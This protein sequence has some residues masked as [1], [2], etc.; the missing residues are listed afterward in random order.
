MQFSETFEWVNAFLQTIYPHTLHKDDTRPHFLL[1][2]LR[3]TKQSYMSTGLPSFPIMIKSHHDVLLPNDCL[4]YIFSMLSEDDLFRMRLVNRRW[5]RISLEDSIW[6]NLYA[7]RFC[8]GKK[9]ELQNIKFKS[10]DPE[11]KPADV[12]SWKQLYFESVSLYK[13]RNM[14]RARRL[15]REAVK[16]SLLYFTTDMFASLPFIITF[17]I[18][19]PLHKLRPRTV[20]FCFT[21][22]C[23]FCGLRVGAQV[24]R[25]RQRRDDDD[26]D[27]PWPAIW[28]SLAQMVMFGLYSTA[29]FRSSFTVLLFVNRMLLSLRNVVP[30]SFGRIF[31]RR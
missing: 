25:P 31:L 26:E 14:R 23:A 17:Y 5:N 30:R 15:K 9:S 22:I 6:S 29:L 12:V 10:R 19:Y 20:F 8:G 3:T 1:S 27:H 11:E 16:R 4:Q 24:V 28:D 18:T 2:H 13:Q 7:D 21:L